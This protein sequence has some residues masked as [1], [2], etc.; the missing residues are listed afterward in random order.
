MEKETQHLTLTFYGGAQSVTGASFVLSNGH[1]KLMVDCGMMQDEHICHECNSE[2]FPYNPADI[3]ALCITHAHM[4]HIGRIPQLVRD[5]FKGKIYM[6][7]PTKD[8]SLV[9]LAD[10]AAVALMH[11]QK[12]G[13]K[14]PYTEEDVEKIVSH[15]EEVEYG[16]SFSV[17]GFDIVFLSAGHILGSA[18]VKV[19]DKNSG[20]KILFS[21]DMGNAPDP[22]LTDAEEVKDATYMVLE[23]VYGNRTHI[24][25]DMRREILLKNLK[26]AIARGGA[27]LVPAFSIA[28]TQMFLYE[29][30]N[31]MDAGD[32]P[33]IPV[34][35]DS[36]LAIKVTD[37]YRKYVSYLNKPAQ[38]ENRKEHDIFGFQNL[39]ET[40]SKDD[41]KDIINAPSPKIII[42]GA[43]M[44]HGGRIQ[45]HEIRYLGDPTTT[46]MVPGYQVVGSIGR[47]LIE[48]AKSVQ[49]NKANVKVR[50]TV[51]NVEGYSA[52]R[53]QEG[54]LN[55]VLPSA[56]SGTL[57]KVF[58]AMGE[59]GAGTHMAQK[60]HDFAG[61]ESMIPKAGDVVTL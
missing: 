53:D 17:D 6:T 12:S 38:E 10:G 22:L 16:E 60:I 41:G 29:L 49:I 52:H 13:E 2:P 1:T 39:K 33:R 9:S 18:M 43:G 26:E 57:K 27:I 34:F 14:P 28:R 30:S 58:L 50:A 54:L 36:P 15:I 51:V 21:G 11:S 61:V 40:L 5:G 46:L 59:L 8:L 47:R 31:F 3:T 42:A 4:D 24:S 7:P 23:T 20:K 55:A 25:H 37:I 35:L 45:E 19:T 44:S 56:E 48:G 32:I